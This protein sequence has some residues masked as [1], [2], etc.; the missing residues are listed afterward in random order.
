ML[1]QHGA[2]TAVSATS[3]S[4]RSADGFTASYSIDTATRVR[5]DGSKAALSGVRDGNQAW[6]TAR[7]S[8]G[9]ATATIVVDRTR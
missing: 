5:V 1:V 7:Q 8:G 3:I 2:V 9:T 4:L 6:I